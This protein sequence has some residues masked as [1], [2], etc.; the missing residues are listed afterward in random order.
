MSVRVLIV[1]IGQNSPPTITEVSRKGQILKNRIFRN[2]VSGEN[3]N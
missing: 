3:L 2:D 1:L